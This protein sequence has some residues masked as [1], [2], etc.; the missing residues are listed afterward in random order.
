MRGTLPNVHLPTR[1]RTR[2]KRPTTERTYLNN[3][4]RSWKRGLNTCTQADFV[5]QTSMG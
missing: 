5:D 1:L 3:D 2:W 4:N